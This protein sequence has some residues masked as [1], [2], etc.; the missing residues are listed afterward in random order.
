MSSRVSP[1]EEYIRFGELE[2]TWPSGPLADRI[3]VCGFQSL[4]VLALLLR[5]TRADSRTYND[6]RRRRGRILE[7]A[8]LVVRRLG[9]LSPAEGIRTATTRE[10]STETLLAE[11]SGSAAFRAEFG[12][13]FG[14]RLCATGVES[15]VSSS[16]DSR[17]PGRVRTD[18]DRL[19]RPATVHALAEAAEQG[20]E[21]VLF[22]GVHQ[23]TECWLAIALDHVRTAARSA[24]EDRRRAAAAWAG[25]SFALECTESVIG[26]LSDMVT[27]DYHPLRVMLRDGSGA[28]SPQ[29][30]ALAP[31]ARRASRELFRVV[32]NAYGL[33]PLLQEPHI[34]VHAFRAV[35]EAGAFADAYQRFLFRHYQLAAGVL[36]AG[37]TGALGYGLEALARRAAVPLFPELDRARAKAAVVSDIRYDDVSGIV[38]RD[39]S[40]DTE[41]P[42]QGAACSDPLVRK[43]V[44]GVFE[45]LRERDA[46][47]WC[48]RFHPDTGRYRS[49]PGNRPYTGRNALRVYAKKILDCC[50]EIVPRFS[51]GATGRN[52]VSVAW[53][54]DITT[55]DGTRVTAEG[56]S[57]LRF[58]PDGLIREAVSLWNHEKVAGEI[59][60]SGRPGP[61][62]RG[63]ERN[64]ALGH[65]PGP[66]ACEAH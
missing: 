35:S 10:D 61:V 17:G 38:Y 58:T 20:P 16:L 63:R 9:D 48:E 64:G 24:A 43:A 47:A 36:G 7:T 66:R 46:E 3:F 42:D 5:N 54:C 57:E 27:A 15:P 41:P 56:R 11:F 34:D 32:G 45:A 49:S 40:G 19:V 55:V 1:Y 30:S 4:E 59:L 2:A 33:V 65:T 18:Y 26:L 25:A 29:A 14:G 8:V 53:S 12:S 37:G 31:T 50:T 60:R 62:G 28:Q 6:R 23:M 51:M 13:S 22:R 44:S 21:D 52:S 39:T